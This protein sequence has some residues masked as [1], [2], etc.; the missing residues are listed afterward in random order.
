MCKVVPE[1]KGIGKSAKEL[2]ARI[3]QVEGKRFTAEEIFNHPW[4]LKEGSKIPLKV[5]FNKMVSFSKFSKVA[6]MSHR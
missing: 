4:M 3:L 2:I 5:S 1:M 6:P